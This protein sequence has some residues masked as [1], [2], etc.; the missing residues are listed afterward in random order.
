MHAHTPDMDNHKRDASDL[1]V[2]ELQQSNGLETYKPFSQ[3][4]PKQSL[5]PIWEWPSGQL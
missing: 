5:G 2:L 4:P 3:T 1:K